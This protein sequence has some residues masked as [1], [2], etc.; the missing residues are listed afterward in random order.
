MAFYYDEER[1]TLEGIP[2]VEETDS[3]ITIATR[4]FSDIVVS[5]IPQSALGPDAEVDTGFLPGI[6]DWQFTN[7]GSYI[8]P[9]GHCAGQAITAI[10]YYTQMKSAGEPSL[11]GRYDEGTRDLWQDDARA[12]RFASTIQK[13]IDWD[14]WSVRYK[15]LAPKAQKDNSMAWKQFVYS[16]MVTGEPQF[17]GIT[18]TTEGGGHAMIVYA[19]SGGALQIADPNYPGSLDRQIWYEDGEFEPYNSGS[20]AQAILEGYGKAYDLILYVGASSL[21]DFGKVSSRWNEFEDGTIGNDR[22]P[23]YV[24]QT[25]NEAGDRVE[26]KDRYAT[27]NKIISINVHSDSALLAYYMTRDSEALSPTQKGGTEFELKPGN[28]YLGMYVVGNKDGSWE[29]VDF[30]Y[31]NVVYETE[32]DK[33]A[34]DFTSMNN[35]IWGVLQSSGTWELAAKNATLQHEDED[36][37]YFSLGVT[38]GASATLIITAKASLQQPTVRFDSGDG[39]QLIKYREPKLYPLTTDF[40][41]DME[42][43][44]NFTTDSS[45]DTLQIDFTLTSHDQYLA[46]SVVF[47]VRYDVEYYDKNGQLTSVSEDLFESDSYCAS[48]Y[49]QTN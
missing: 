11:Y 6:D 48:F 36:T 41:L 38:K 13:D 22:F 28:N 39:Y 1:G 46:I 15:K 10:W 34:G 17:V 45:A 5:S 35:N 31:F 19:I 16:M 12:Y 27:T 4:H 33:V 24:I 37:N 8:A 23:A 44:Y 3:S 30:K 21:V 20:D 47:G 25:K 14:G 49:I 40:V 43:E 2:T 7:Y 29:Y 18:N 26:L 32:K 42:G 9:P